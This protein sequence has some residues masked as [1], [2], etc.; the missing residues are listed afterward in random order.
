MN[1]AINE[2]PIVDSARLL[3]LSWRNLLGDSR[4]AGFHNQWRHRIRN[5]SCSA[6]NFAVDLSLFPTL[7]SAGNFVYSRSKLERICPRLTI[8]RT[9]ME[10]IISLLIIL[11]PSRL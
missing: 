6:N 3:G 2:P 4:M 8:I 10:L 1:T 9:G 7:S 5:L 11:L